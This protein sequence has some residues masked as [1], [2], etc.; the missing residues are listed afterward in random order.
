MP[1][2]VTPAD[3][4]P[5]LKAYRVWA[6]TCPFIARS[7]M[8]GIF[9]A[10]LASCFSPNLDKAF[11]S[12][13]YWTIEHYEVYRIVT[14]VFC[15]GGIVTVVFGLMTFNRIGP[16]LERSLGSTGLL[17]LMVTLTVV[18]NLAFILACYSLVMLGKGKARFFSSS[19]VWNLLI[20]LIAVECMMT[21]D[22]PRRF[23]I[24]PYDIPGRYYPLFLA[25]VFAIM[26][27]D[28]TG[29]FCA[30]GIGYAYAHGRLDSIKPSRSK[31]AS[32]ESGCLANFVQRPGYIINGAAMGAEAFSTPLN[33]PADHPSNQRNEGGGGGGFASMFGGGAGG[34]ESGN[35]ESGGGFGSNNVIKKGGAAGGASGRGRGG[36]SFAGSGQTL[37]GGGGGGGGGSRSSGRSQTLHDPET[38]R[39]ARLAALEA[40]TS[41]G[42][43]GGRGGGGRRTAERGGEG[44]PLLAASDHD[45]L[46]LQDMGFTATEARE[47]LQFTN[48]DVEA[49][50]SYLAA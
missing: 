25:T 10:Y 12:S 17:A 16:N 46:T 4:N 39:M 43:R 3:E 42:G 34:G 35:G 32:W 36:D 41:P 6:S 21:P 23:F 20:A 28:F 47:A 49:A 45:V 27:R 22:A 31:L 40:R 38:A 9:V 2:P 5:V 33:N 11:N 1:E 24:L 14:T 30:V 18:T 8:V 29:I 26:G 44:A 37:G 50:A 48:G 15:S 7:T 19:G 13:P